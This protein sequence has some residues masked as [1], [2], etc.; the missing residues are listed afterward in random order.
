[1]AHKS[2]RDACEVASLSPRLLAEPPIV[3]LVPLV[4]RNAILTPL[5]ALGI[6]CVLDSKQAGIV[7]AIERLLEVRH[8]VATL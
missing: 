7:L 8:K 1:M 2:K 4:A 3:S 6:D 5:D